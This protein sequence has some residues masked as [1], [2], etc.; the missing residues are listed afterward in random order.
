MKLEKI[1]YN[2]LVRALFAVTLIMLS[3]APV[4]AVAQNSTSSTYTNGSVSYKLT[5]YCQ[6]SF[7]FQYTRIVYDPILNAIID[8]KL[9]SDGFTIIYLNNDSNCFVPVNG[10]ICYIFFDEQNSLLYVQTTLTFCIFNGT[11]VIKTVNSLAQ[12]TEGY[13]FGK[14]GVIDTSNGEIYSLVATYFTPNANAIGVINT[15]NYSLIVENISHS[16]LYTFPTSIVYDNY[17]NKLFIT[18]VRNESIGQIYSVNPYNLS[19]TLIANTSP[20]YAMTYYEDNLYVFLSN[21]SYG[22]CTMDVVNTLTGKV[23]PTNLQLPATNLAITLPNGE[24]YVATDDGTWVIN[25]N[26]TSVIAKIPVVPTAISSM[27]YDPQANL[28]FLDAEN[29]FLIAEVNPVTNSVIGYA[30]P[31]PVTPNSAVFDAK[32]SML[33]LGMPYSDYL[34]EEQLSPLRIVKTIGPFSAHVTSIACDPENGYL[35]IGLYDNQIA[36]FNPMTNSIITNISYS[37]SKANSHYVDYI[38]SLN[39]VVVSTSSGVVG[40]N[41]TTNSVIYEVNTTLPPTEIAYDPNNGNLYL[42]NNGYLYQESKQ[43]CVINARNGNKVGIITAK[44]YDVTGVVYDPNTSYI[45]IT[46]AHPSCFYA[47]NPNTDTIV[48]NVSL[49]FTPSTLLYNPVN[50]LIYLVGGVNEKGEIKV[51]YPYGS[52]FVSTIT[53]NGTPDAWTINPQTG[54][55]VVTSSASQAFYPT[56]TY[57]NILSLAQAVTQTTTQSTTQ[58]TFQ[59]TSTQITQSTTETSTTQAQSSQTIS[60]TPP[61]TSP[62]PPVTTSRSSF[63]PLLIVVVVVV[64]L[65]I[66]AMVL[67]LRR[68]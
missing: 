36:V 63:N 38:P 48:Y 16:G 50:K 43:I 28:V 64:L 13:G 46:T 44:A 15:S 51:F 41:A 35:Y 56:L 1:E 20:A 25:A 11:E 53:I 10:G 52:Y 19:L 29:L 21:R 24:I 22:K 47:I 40:I 60:T 32:N 23:T 62:K 33:Y 8:Y 14:G 45:Y 5:E 57:F 31:Y 39:E 4:Y 58:T 30:N 54:C 9:C 68:R 6:Q 59:Q 17:T 3:I 7:S 65:V 42:T 2:N 26:T 66:V 61:V 27:A 49:G 55:L 12:G 34:F 37:P 18:V 67:I